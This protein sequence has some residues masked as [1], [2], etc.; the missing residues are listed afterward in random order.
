MKI[1]PD[2]LSHLGYHF[3]SVSHQY[4]DYKCIIYGNTELYGIFTL[5]MAYNGVWY[6]RG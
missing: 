3:K 5:N 2:S 4:K 1:I 6:T